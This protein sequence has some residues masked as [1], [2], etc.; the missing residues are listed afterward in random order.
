MPYVEPLSLIQLNSSRFRRF[1]YVC[2][3][4]ENGG[5]NEHRPWYFD[6][7]GTTDITDTYRK[8]VNAH[9][10]LGMNR[11]GIL[12]RCVLLVPYSAT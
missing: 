2:R 9:L 11:L 5:D 4:M 3:L 10:E 8:F 6:T 7:N 12:L 1:A